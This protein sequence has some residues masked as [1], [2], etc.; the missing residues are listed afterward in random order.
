MTN[1]YDEF[2]RE[3]LFLEYAQGIVPDCDSIEE[4]QDKMQ[5]YNYLMSELVIPSH[6]AVTLA[7]YID[8]GLTE[9]YNNYWEKYNG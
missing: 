4:L 9:V 2:E 5:P 3:I 1:I 8:F 6:Q 7:D